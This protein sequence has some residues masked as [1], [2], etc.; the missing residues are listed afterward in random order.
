MTKLIA[1]LCLLCLLAVWVSPAHAAPPEVEALV[2]QLADKDAAV[3][4]K[5]AKELGKLK[6]K[7]KDAIPALKTAAADTDEDVR[8]VAKRALAAVQGAE[9][10]A[11]PA[12]LDGELAL[13]V[14]GLMAKDGKSKLAAVAKLE[15]M[16]EKAKPAGAALVE[17]GIM[18]TTPAVK[19]AALAAFE[20]IDPTVC[21]EVVTL[22]FD[23]DTGKRDQAVAN[24][25]D[26]GQRAT[27]GVPAL[28]H[29]HEQRR[30]KVKYTPSHVL[31]ALIRVAPKDEVVQRALL[32]CLGGPDNA[33]PI[34]VETFNKLTVGS[35]IDS[36]PGRRQYVLDLVRELEIDDKSKFPALVSGIPQSG[37]PKE[38][39]V[40]IAEL[41]ELKVPAKDK[42][43]GLLLAL[44]KSRTSRHLIIDEIGKLG[45]DGKDAVPTLKAL[46][47]DKE[48]TVRNSAAAALDA[49]TK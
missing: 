44:G 2:K 21:K 6:E 15:A 8:E 22:L 16:G 18:S 30:A 11:D 32:E 7:A 5:A 48:E 27:G 43:K 4:L 36:F 40:L 25:A 3:R 12:K 10:K 29:Y 26:M 13:A 14:K 19:D 49:I 47:T 38:Q 37:Q 39:A 33:L 42:C 46:K 35:R 24:L 23:E 45:A 1:S 41:G 20:K 17:Y 28:K 34:P 9:P 31:E